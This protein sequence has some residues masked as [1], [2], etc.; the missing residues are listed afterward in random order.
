MFDT[1]HYLHYVL[2]AEMDFHY[3]DDLM[4]LSHDS[5]LWHELKERHGFTYVIF[6]KLTESGFF[7]EAFDSGSDALLTWSARK[8]AWHESNTFHLPDKVQI[9]HSSYLPA[10][11]GRQDSTLMDLLWKVQHNARNEKIALVYTPASLRAMLACTPKGINK[12]SEFVDNRKKAPNAISVIQIDMTAEAL[13]RA[14]LGDGSPFPDLEPAL[15]KGLLSNMNKPLLTVLDEQ[16]GERLTDFSTRQNDMH[17]ILMF[18]ALESMDGQD[19]TAQLSD[20]AEYLRLSCQYNLSI[21]YMLGNRGSEPLRRSVIYG[22]LKEPAFRTALRTSANALRDSNP[23]APMRFL[24]QQKFGSLPQTHPEHR[25]LHNDSLVK[26]VTALTLPEDYLHFDNTLKSVPEELTQAVRTLWSKKRNR[27]VCEKIEDYCSAL[28]SACRDK[29][30]DT[31][32]DALLL[33]RLCAR[34]LCANVAMQCNL[35]PVFKLGSTVLS[36]SAKFF[37][38]QADIAD[39]E[40]IRKTGIHAGDVSHMHSKLT[41]ITASTTLELEKVMLDAQRSDL[42]QC[43]TFFNMNTRTQKEIEDFFQNREQAQKEVLNQ[44]ESASALI[45]QVQNHQPE[46]PLSHEPVPE[47]PVKKSVSA[48][49]D[50]A[51]DDEY[52]P[53][54]FDPSWRQHTGYRP[55]WEDDPL[56]KDDPE[57]TVHFV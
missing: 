3:T 55:P 25:V 56:L 37:H 22:K 30:W 10:K 16:L 53:E 47:E 33:L 54:D 4:R 9:Q 15:K 38:S 27:F 43:I 42:R 20:Q 49:H 46:E 13:E 11:L 12:I 40:R 28:Y 51:Q 50:W 44:L 29:D 26:T 32:T 21:A 7:L 24:F 41:S 18:Q 31:V 57:D 36:D 5:Y 48:Y 34:H 14:F 17:N 1:K 39:M 8:K 45:S 23:E 19:T 6:V 35:D 2:D 52:N